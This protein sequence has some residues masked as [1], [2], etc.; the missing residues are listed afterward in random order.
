MFT[1]IVTPARLAF[2]FKDD[3][4]TDDEGVDHWEIINYIV[5]ICF[6]IDIFFTFNSAYIDEDFKVISSRKVIAVNYLKGWF[7]I[8][9]V[10]IF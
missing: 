8:D 4:T 7:T 10:A 3:S 1:C 2:D 6:L 5:D 9:F